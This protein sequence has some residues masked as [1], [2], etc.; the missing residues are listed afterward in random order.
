MTVLKLSQTKVNASIA[1]FPKYFPQLKQLSLSGC[2]SI[3]DD[4]ISKL[5][6]LPLE[7]LNLSGCVNISDKSIAAIVQCC[8]A[9]LTTLNVSQTL[10]TD[11]SFT[12]YE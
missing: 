10:V 12:K 1:E 2:A 8:S 5:T 6:D 9:T 7:K 3:K 4:V 11:I